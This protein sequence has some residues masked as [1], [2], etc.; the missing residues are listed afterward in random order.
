M[1]HHAA[2]HKCTNQ[3]GGQHNQQDYEDRPP[4]SIHIHN[5]YL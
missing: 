2:G 3:G 1:R 5:L 4:E